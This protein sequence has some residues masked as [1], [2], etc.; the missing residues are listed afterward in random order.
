[1]IH[2]RGDSARAKARGNECT[3]CLRDLELSV[4]GKRSSY[5]P[6]AAYINDQTSN[7]KPTACLPSRCENLVDLL[8]RLESPGASTRWSH[9]Y[10]CGSCQMVK[11]KDNSASMKTIWR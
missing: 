11:T 2:P 7:A 8:Q 9:P 1:M 6:L 5:F 4:A 3:T 10:L